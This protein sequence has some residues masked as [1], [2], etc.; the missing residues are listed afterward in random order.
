MCYVILLVGS[1]W[2]MLLLCLMVKWVDIL[3]LV[4]VKIFIEDERLLLVVKWI[5][6]VLGDLDWKCLDVLGESLKVILLLVR[7]WLFIL[8]KGSGEVCSVFI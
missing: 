2:I 7:I 6:I 1:I 4:L 5:I 3:L 8:N